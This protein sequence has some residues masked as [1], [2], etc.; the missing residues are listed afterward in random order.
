LIVS[1]VFISISTTFFGDRGVAHLTH[2]LLAVGQRPFLKATI[3]LLCAL[4]CGLVEQQPGERRDRMNAPG[5]LVI[6]TR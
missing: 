3:T 1:S 5:A 4:L 6:E 2:E